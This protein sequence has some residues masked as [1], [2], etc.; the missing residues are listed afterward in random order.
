MLVAKNCVKVLH[1]R[2]SRTEEAKHPSSGVP[3]QKRREI[4]D[5]ALAMTL[6]RLSGWSGGATLGLAAALVQA[7]GTAAPATTMGASRELVLAYDDAHAS[8]TIAFPSMTYESVVRFALPDG[9]HRPIRLRLQAG[10]E[11]R[12][13]VSLYE[14]TA[15]E[16]PGQTLRTVSYDV[17]KDGVSD[18]RDGRWLVAE[19][20]DMKPLKG[21]VWIGV[22][23]AG[24]EPTLWASSVVSGQSFVRNSDPGNFMGLLP[25]KR[26]P[27]LRLEVVP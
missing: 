11:G 9:E 20:G 13:D 19:L 5:D 23:K 15:L 1:R 17:T 18:G 7:C 26:T 2:S 16:T 22:R 24:G 25:T 10:A 8:G 21:V 27:M 14:S 4:A 3:V 12:L 6:A